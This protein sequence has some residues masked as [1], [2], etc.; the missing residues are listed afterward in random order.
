MFMEIK[1]AGRCSI[2]SKNTL[3][4]VAAVVVMAAP[5]CLTSEVALASDRD[6]TS[7]DQVVTNTTA[8]DE[9]HNHGH[10]DQMGQ[11]GVVTDSRDHADRSIN[12]ANMSQGS[13]ELHEYMMKSVPNM[14]M[15][16]NADQDFATMM[17]KHHQVG[18]EMARL[19]IQHGKDH[20]ARHMA[21]D[22]IAAEK[23][24]IHRLKDWQETHDNTRAQ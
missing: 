18:I 2:F 12:D 23:K 15:S 21:E 8:A 14:P 10:R 19:Q 17:I 1:N 6:Q 5:L 22:I 16:G 3:A 24:E 20:E 9:L 13:R 11:N 7:Q 4:A